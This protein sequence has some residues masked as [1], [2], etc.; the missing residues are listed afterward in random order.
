MS[1]APHSQPGLE[2]AGSRRETTVDVSI[3]AR[4]TV[5][6]TDSR[7]TVLAAL[8]MSLF[9]CSA[10][11]WSNASSDLLRRTIDVTVTDKS[12][13]FATGLVREDF[14]VFEN[15]SYHPVTA[16][17]P[18]SFR[19][20][21]TRFIAFIF[22]N[23][24]FSLQ[25][26]PI[27]RRAALQM[28]DETGPNM[29]IAVFWVG[30]NVRMIQPFTRDRKAVRNA[31]ELAT[32][33]GQDQVQSDAGTWPKNALNTSLQAATEVASRDPLANSGAGA[34]LA[35]SVGLYAWPGR[36]HA[37]IFRENLED[38]RIHPKHI[39]RAVRLANE[40]HISVYPV[41]V[42]VVDSHSDHRETAETSLGD[43][44]ESTGGLAF[45]G[46]NDYADATA[47]VV[48]ELSNYYEL[49]WLPTAEWNGKR[50]TARVKDPALRVR[51][52][53][54]F[55][56]GFEKADALLTEQLELGGYPIDAA[57]RFGI[58]RFWPA[59]G[60][61]WLCS[62]HVQ[63][64][65]N[66]LYLLFQI[67]SAS[68]EVVHR[69]TFQAEEPLP[70]APGDYSLE[71][72]TFSDSTHIIG[73]GRLSFSV[74]PLAPGPWISDVVPIRG[75]VRPTLSANSVDDPLR[76]I[77]FRMLPKVDAR[78]ERDAFV[79]FYFVLG[80]FDEPFQLKG[81]L[82]QDG[83]NLSTVEVAPPASDDK[84]RSR[85]LTGVDMRGRPPGK[86]TIRVSGKANGQRLVA[87][88]RFVVE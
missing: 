7:S 44:A 18:P 5:G 46:T 60:A 72:V 42:R 38:E 74:S 2:Y 20:K 26:S 4:G 6:P 82:L 70:L 56:D 77:D 36:K 65:R 12:G 31:I 75:R 86:Y 79:P 73:G 69:G 48:G 14:E 41:E 40:A 3:E 49:R 10:P 53:A 67:R 16:A 32:T 39:R 28:F 35:M 64:P 22:D 58:Y 52:A 61:K 45:R 85:Q 50:I 68:G 37:I 1:A 76:L 84:G 59:D 62:L 27:A 19:L 23:L 24:H 29:R 25:S 21:D 34:V 51:C 8:L 57:L 63:P 13:H 80:G 15:N 87:E 88:L 55:H 78:F 17:L 81:E 83:R 43:L 66:D 33:P 30:K 9:S 71:A 11:L 47:H 54:V